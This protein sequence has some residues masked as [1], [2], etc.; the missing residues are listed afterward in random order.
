M[1]A[2]KLKWHRQHSWFLKIK[3]FEM[4]EKWIRERISIMLWTKI[5]PIVYIILCSTNVVW[6]MLNYGKISD[7]YIIRLK[8]RMANAVRHPHI[9]VYS[10]S[11][12]RFI[13]WRPENEICEHFHNSSIWNKKQK[14]VHCVQAVSVCPD[15]MSVW[16]LRFFC[17]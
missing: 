1:Q 16:L 5:S 4:D 2:L 14:R 12:R 9:Y 13:L 15:S 7:K 3:P 17:R 6:L 8:I 10:G 11:I